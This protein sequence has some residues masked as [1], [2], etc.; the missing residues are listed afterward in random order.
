MDKQKW[1]KKGPD[2]RE[3][4]SEVK[5]ERKNRPRNLALIIPT[6]RN[7]KLI[8]THVDALSKQTTKDFDIIIVYGEKDRFINSPNWASISHI[9]ERGRNGCAGAYYLGEKYALKEGYGKIVLADDD[10]LPESNNLLENE[11][12]ELESNDVV[13]PRAFRGTRTNPEYWIHYYGGMTRKVLE[14]VGLTFIPLYVGGEDL[15]FMFRIQEEGF[16]FHR[17]TSAVVHPRTV[18]FVLYPPQMLY[19]YSR[20]AVI[21]LFLAKKYVRCAWL[22]FT[23]LMMAASFR[24][25]GKRI[26]AKEHLRI[27]R[28]ATGM[29]FFEEIATDVKPDNPLKE[30]KSPEVDVTLDVDSKEARGQDSLNQTLS[31]HINNRNAWREYG[32][33]IGNFISTAAEARKYLGKRVLFAEWCSSMDLVVMLMARSSY[34]KTGGNTYAISQNRGL[35]RICSG[36]IL[37]VGITPIMAALALM[38]T[39]YGIANKTLNHIDSH[40]YGIEKYIQE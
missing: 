5:D 30:V 31:L 10:C 18:P 21:Q 20:G 2:L 39:V 13:V 6:Y 4:I 33:R 22:I 32:Q 12:M 19:Y 27:V 15:D 14:K 3:L 28:N 34:I 1:L 7:E 29:K 36:L 17:I 23:I 40:R 35:A 38:F 25:L 37:L 26:I 11:A 24:I 8:Q 9:R 16:T